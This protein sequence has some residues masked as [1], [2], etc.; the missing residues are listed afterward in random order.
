MAVTACLVAGCQ[1]F[2]PGFGEFGPESVRS[3]RD[4]AAQHDTTLALRLDGVLPSAL[5]DAGVECWLVVSDGAALDP[6]MAHLLVATTRAEGRGVVLV[7]DGDGGPQRFALGRGMGGNS[8]LYEVADADDDQGLAELLA[9]RLAAVAPGRIA[10]NRAPG[11]ALADGLSASSEAW[12]RRE[13]AP[14]FVERFVF[15]APLAEVFLSRQLD[16]EAA[17]FEE[18]ARLTQA[19]LAE[20]LSDQVV[21]AAGTSL[22]DLEWAVRERALDLGVELAFSPRAVVYRAGEEL[23][24]D[25]PAEGDPLLQPGDLFFLTAGVSYLD[26]GNRVGRWAYLLRQG[27]SAA[28]SWV[29]DA[30]GELADASERIASEL[31]PGQGAAEVDAVAE[32]VADGLEAGFVGIERVGR[33]R[34]GRADPLA[35]VSPVGLWHPS[36]RLVADTGLAVVV[37]IEVA[38]PEYTSPLRL[39]SIETVLLSADGTRFVVAPQRTPLLID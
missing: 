1:A 26:Y 38:R 35:S 31:R 37:R 10:V 32:G 25:R 8:A 9:A 24:T 36:F 21:F 28:P 20:V 18:S 34:E 6:V 3:A 23:D 12:L 16:L 2:A 19:I 14:E 30:L 29:S 5:R 15:A 4:R 7:C 11:S 27:E 13:I 39:V 17:L 22:R 33:W